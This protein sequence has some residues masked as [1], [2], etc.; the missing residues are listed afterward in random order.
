MRKKKSLFKEHKEEETSDHAQAW[1]EPDSTVGRKEKQGRV[2]GGVGEGEQGA[3][4]P[5]WKSGRRSMV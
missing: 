2:K 1:C 4:I 5:C 3:G